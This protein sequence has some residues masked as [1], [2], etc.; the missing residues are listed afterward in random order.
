M[1]PPLCLLLDASLAKHY[2]E[3]HGDIQTALVKWHGG[4]IYNF[5][6]YAGRALII[7]VGEYGV[8]MLTRV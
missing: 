7:A 1:P 2:S 3:I 6:L 4:D 8:E 5:G